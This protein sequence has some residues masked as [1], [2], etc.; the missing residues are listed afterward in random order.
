MKTLVG[1]LGAAAVLLALAACGGGGAT[2][3]MRTIA[4]GREVSGRLTEHDPRLSDSA[5]YQMYR[6][7]ARAGDLMEIDLSSSDFDTYA[8]LQDDAGHEL[9]HDD[10]SGGGTN[11]RI[12]YAIPAT[13]TYRVI[14]KP[15]RPNTFGAYQLAVTRLATAVPGGNGMT[16]RRG[17]ALSGQLT[18][19]DQRL[20]DNS[21]YHLY[22]YQG[23]Q[24]ERIT[25][26]V[27][28]SDFDA[29]VIVQDPLGNEVG[30][31]DDSGEGTNARL[32]LTLATTGLYRIVVNAYRENS[33][34]AYTLW[35]H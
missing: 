6:F 30:R 24:G 23:T 1:R 9:T 10:D 16:I 32:T 21:V 18:L 28:S 27:M 29:Y 20:S 14:V 35:V 26:D 13:G 19:G 11:S 8:V 31:D 5:A 34:G 22:Y 2:A 25:I 12:V 33:A 3:P 4:P 15:Y 17:Q 7:K